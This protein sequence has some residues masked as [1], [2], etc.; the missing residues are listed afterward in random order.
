MRA[1]SRSLLFL[2]AMLASGAALAQ[3]PPGWQIGWGV[4]AVPL[5]PWASALIAVLLAIAAYAFMKRRARDGFMVLL[6]GALAAGLLVDAGQLARA[7]GYDFTIESSSGTQFV[8]CGLLQPGAAGLAN[9][10][11]QEVLGPVVGTDV[12]TTINAVT[13]VNWGGMTPPPLTGDGVCVPGLKLSP[14][15]SCVLPCDSGQEV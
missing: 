7:V 14:G 8:S 11:A 5:S 6:G 1:P 2:G 13:P 12:T 9:A 4:A 3:Q 10:H 15:Q